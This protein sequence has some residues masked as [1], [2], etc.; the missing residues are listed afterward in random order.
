M[1]RIQ[2]R[3]ECDGPG[4]RSL[5]FGMWVQPTVT[6]K[7]PSLQAHTVESLACFGDAAVVR[8]NN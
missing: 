1:G 5:R 2:A 4:S 3:I 6:G 8:S 7:T